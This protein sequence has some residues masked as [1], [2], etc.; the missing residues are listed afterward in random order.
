MLT[1]NVYND[2]QRQ[3]RHCDVTLAPFICDVDVENNAHQRV[4]R[5]RNLG[6][7]AQRVNRSY[8]WLAIGR[9][10]KRDL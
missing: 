10:L 2:P 9:L 8:N 7:G 6:R 1:S 5:K 3:R 4:R